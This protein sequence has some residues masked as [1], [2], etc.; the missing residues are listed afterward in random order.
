M[1]YNAEYNTSKMALRNDFI[2]Y[3]GLLF[4]HTKEYNT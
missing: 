2:H 1:K 3:D 4:K